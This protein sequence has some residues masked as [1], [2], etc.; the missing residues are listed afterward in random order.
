MSPELRS[1]TAFAIAA[2]VTFV[3]TPLVIR[4]AMRTAFL[5]RPSGYKSHAGPTPYLGGT[6]IM[7][8]VAAA[9]LLIGG[10]AGEHGV[11]LACA[12]AI[13]LVGTIDDRV[14][15]SLW[16]RLGAEVVIAAVLWSTGRGWDV[17]GSAPADLLLTI[18]W[19]VGVMNAFNIMDN[20]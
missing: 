4:V 10:G 17:L 16:A 6:A 18:V 7:A 19:V 2:S 13:C 12:L 8:G 9:V 3:A 20:M 14:N 1:A 5:D 15:L 11:M